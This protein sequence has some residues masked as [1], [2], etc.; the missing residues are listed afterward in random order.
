MLCA[1]LN[2][3]VFFL[4]RTKC[5][6]FIYLFPAALGVCCC[7]QAFSSGHSWLWCEVFSLRWLLLLQSMGSRCVGLVAS[8]YVESSHTRNQTR[9]PCIGRPI[10][11]H[12][13]TREVLTRLMLKCLLSSLVAQSVKSLLAM[14]ETRVRSLGREDPPGEGNG[15]SLWLLPRESHGQRSLAGYSPWGCK[16]CTQLSG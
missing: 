14:Q 8:Q 3:G 15:N 11:K 13:T 12:W 7:T 4:K 5:W 2:R 6:L 16:S 9:V 10:P 1:T